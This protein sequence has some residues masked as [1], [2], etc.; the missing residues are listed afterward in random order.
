[1]A[2]VTKQHIRWRDPIAVTFG[3]TGIDEEEA[4]MLARSRL[5]AQFPSLDKPNQC[6]Y[7]VR[8]RGDVAIAYG[9]E[10]SPVIYIGE[11]N[12]STRLYSHANWIAPLLVAVPNAQIEVRVADCV[13][14]NDTKLCQ[15]VEADLIE[16]FIDKYN[17]LPWFNRQREPKY[18]GKRTYSSAVRTEF[19]QRIGKV[20]GAKYLWAI[21]PTHNNNQHDPYAAGWYE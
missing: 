14:V 18:V 5:K 15:Y 8:L 10:F 21:R 6:V 12:A 1:M 19:N 7:V 2:E 11:G 4:L 9:N 17:C 13:R 16:S 3:F 20:Q